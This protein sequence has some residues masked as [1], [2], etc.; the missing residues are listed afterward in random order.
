[1]ASSYNNYDAQP[2]PAPYDS[3]SASSS[4]RYPSP[5][6]QQAAQKPRQHHHHHQQ[7]PHAAYTPKQNTAPP[8]TFQ[9]GTQI[10][11]GSHNCVVERYLSEGGFAHV[12]VVKID[13]VVD[14][15]N[16]AVLKR[17]AV[18]DKEALANMRT[19]VDTMGGGYE[20]FL[21]ME[22]CAGGGLIDFMNTRLQHRL[23]EPEIL[24][25]F[26]DAAEGVA[27]MH[28]LQPPLLHRDLKIENI[29]ITPEPRTYK[30]CDFGSSAEP[31]PAG[32]NVTECRMIE[33][34]IQKHTTL[35]YRSPEM[36]DVFRGQAI[37]EKSDIWALGV[38]LY[39]LCYYTTPFEDQGQ[40]AILNAS[41][42]YPPYPQFSSQVKGL[43]GSMLQEDPRKR[44]NIYE[45]VSTVCRLRGKEVPIKNIYDKPPIRTSSLPTSP[46]V[47]T[48][49]TAALVKEAPQPPPKTELPQ[50]QQM[51]RGRPPKPDSESPRKAPASTSRGP[52]AKVTNDPFAALD[53]SSR[54]DDISTRFPSVEQFS[55]LHDQ[56]ARFD[57]D[58]PPP[59]PPQ[60]NSNNL[61]TRV[62][63]KLADQAFDDMPQ[64]TASKSQP[65]PAE[66]SSGSS[67]L[68]L[69]ESRRIKTGTGGASSSK[70]A[71]ISQGTMTGPPSNNSSLPRNVSTDKF[72]SKPIADSVLM[73]NT[74]TGT[75]I[76][77][78]LGE[79]RSSSTSPYS[80]ANLARRSF[81]PPRPVSTIGSRPTPSAKARPK[82]THIESNLD[83]LRDLDS[84]SR[85]RQPHPTQPPKLENSTTGRS[86]S[87]AVSEHI[88]SSVDFL[89]VLQLESDASKGGRVDKRVPN[90]N[91][92]SSKHKKTPSV[93]LVNTKNKLAGRFGEAFKMFETGNSDSKRS[94]KPPSPHSSEF[95]SDEYLGQEYSDLQVSSSEIPAEIRREM[96]KRQLQEEERRVEAA[97][98]AYKQSVAE[99]GPGGRPPRPRA[100]SIQRKVQ[101]LL[102]EDERASPAPRTA[103]GYGRYTDAP[104]VKPHEALEKQLQGLSMTD[105]MNNSEPTSAS[106]EPPPSVKSLVNRYARSGGELQPI[107]Q[108]SSVPTSTA[109]TPA[110]STARQVPPR[111]APKPEKLRRLIPAEP[112]PD[113]GYGSPRTEIRESPVQDAQ[114]PGFSGR[115][116]ELLEFRKRFPS[117]SG[118]E[119]ETAGTYARR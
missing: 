106:S 9:P 5:N 36:I 117:L 6:P 111:P 76:R 74:S 8:G 112:R 4:Y 96:E 21:L 26:N 77:P 52:S 88:E 14:G 78:P 72:Q 13:Q 1:M 7:Q 37:D 41:F 29:L 19:E 59:E 47:T 105:S 119:F 108:S 95:P 116:D 58:S 71:M 50:I 54:D 60:A 73:T 61:S 86:T 57:F 44:P 103:E 63:H 93:T 82:S 70:P 3:S 113:F 118:S 94:G 49:Q 10:K 109:S 100:G 30:L 92:P 48:Y 39:K 67:S 91:P 23:T 17:V 18:P 55:L 27:T 46:P 79:H 81:E 2:Q 32:K 107:S 12:Y 22:F 16:I 89:R 53:T 87:S 20:V 68:S 69:P 99:R 85:S 104:T 102:N 28:Y 38:L 97:A 83:F 42:K 114:S 84:S 34:D 65:L 33:D 25:I 115:D 31:R 110:T 24:K 56:G 62:M 43:I 11:V 90:P 101:A 66:P 80:P 75:F 51:R 35:Q 98:A 15:T 45:I 64:I 40:L